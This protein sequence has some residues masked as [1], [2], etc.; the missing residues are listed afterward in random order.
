MT[1]DLITLIIRWHEAHL[2]ADVWPD[3]LRM[4]YKDGMMDLYD[5][6]IS[7]RIGLALIADAVLAE[8][9]TRRRDGSFGLSAR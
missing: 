2:D 8:I 5:H 3:G 9:P 4:D 6:A 1:T 7:E